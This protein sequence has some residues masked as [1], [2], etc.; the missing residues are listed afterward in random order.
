MSRLRRLA[1]V[2]WH[3]PRDRGRRLRVAKGPRRWQRR[4][5]RTFYV[6]VAP[7]VI[8]FVIL[9]LAPII[10]AFGVSLTN[11]DGSSSFWRFIGFRN[12]VEFF[13]KDTDGWA[14]LLRTLGY[15]AIV[16]PLSVA[17][18]LALAI[19]VN[20]RIRAR[21]ALRALF[22]LPSVVPVVATAITFRLIFNRDAGLF[23]GLMG[24]FG[25]HDV[26][27]LSDPWAFYALVVMT[28]WGLGGG[29]I[30]SLAALQD[31]P[32]ELEEAARLDG[33]SR[34]RYI[35]SILVPLISPVLYCQVVTGIIA[36]L[37]MLVQPLLLAETNRIA[38]SAQVPTSSTLFMVKVYNEFFI[39]NR[40]GYGSAMLWIFF[41]VI[42]ILTLLLQRLSR[43]FV[44]YQVGGD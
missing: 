4:Q 14:S 19:L 37:Q 44:F 40:F 13:T 31:V 42:L 23:S 24:L 20:Q 36:A 21:G 15:A 32:S 7:W 3:S 30:I 6:F 2:A 9:T 41:L 10:Y 39:S 25:V 26:T 18:G 8:G 43:R 38:S 12:Y 1:T 27:W 35:R 16:V 22:F 11:Y 17:G 28:L 33:A 5:G 34:W 29:M